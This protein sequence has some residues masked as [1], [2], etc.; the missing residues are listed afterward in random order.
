MEWRGNTNPFSQVNCNV[1]NE[2]FQFLV[3]NM[4]IE[5]PSPLK[6]LLKSGQLQNLVLDGVD[7]TARQWKSLMTILLEEADSCRNIRYILLPEN[8]QNNKNSY[9]E[10]LIEKCPLLQRLDVATFSICQH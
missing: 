8:F 7:F 9:L 4:N 5:K 3:I 1:V 10:R 2:L 6:L